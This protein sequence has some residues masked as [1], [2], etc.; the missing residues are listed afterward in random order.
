M[1]FWG[2]ARAAGMEMFTFGRRL[3][4]LVGTP[5][6]IGEFGLH[7]Q[8]PW[9]IRTADVILVGSGDLFVPADATLDYDEYDWDEHESLRDARLA[10][11]VPDD[12]DVP[13]VSAVEG[14]NVGGARIALGEAMALEL[15][16]NDSDD[17]E[18]GEYWRLL[19]YDA[20]HFVVSASGASWGG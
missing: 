19:P 15:F 2:H 1:P 14:D 10:A 3:P 4:A 17:G 20:A 12:G 8:C 7:L 11:L 6:E 18:Y 9:R 16:P 5:R 13:V